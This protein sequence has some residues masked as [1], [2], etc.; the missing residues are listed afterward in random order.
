MVE[1]KSGLEMFMELAVA[2]QLVNDI[3]D[4]HLG[5]WL[6]LK[7]TLFSSYHSISVTSENTF[8]PRAAAKFNQC[9]DGK[10]KKKKCS[11]SP[12]IGV[13]GLEEPS[14]KEKPPCVKEHSLE[15]PTV[16]LISVFLCPSLFSPPFLWLGWWKLTC[17][18]LKRQHWPLLL[19][20]ILGG[21]SSTLPT[22]PRL[23]LSAYPKVHFTVLFFFS[24]KE[25]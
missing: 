16:A 4:I 22:W 3:N 21:L 2:T 12:E 15:C 11:L 19:S 25:N 24:G 8:T 9:L 17:T 7:L 13:Q 20:S 18:H 5:L 23:V 6:T 14:T 1:N 10:K